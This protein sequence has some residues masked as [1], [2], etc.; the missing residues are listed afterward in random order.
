MGAA[1]LDRSEVRVDSSVL[2]MSMRSG[3]KHEAAVR[4]GRFTFEM[5]VRFLGSIPT[6]VGGATER[7]IQS[8]GGTVSEATAVTEL[9]VVEA[10]RMSNSLCEAFEEPPY[11]SVVRKKIYVT[12]SRALET[13]SSRKQYRTN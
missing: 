5:F 12:G 13:T 3:V 6:V 7:P 9:V 4:K 10:L 1:R 2:G 11:I 8:C